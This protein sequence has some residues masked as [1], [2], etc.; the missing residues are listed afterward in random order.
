[1]LEHIESDFVILSTRAMMD[2]AQRV[3]YHV[4]TFPE[5]RG[6][7]S[8]RQLVNSLY[9][10]EFADGEMEAEVRV[11]LRGKKIFLFANAAR[12]SLGY[13]V[14]QNKIELYHTIDALRRAQAES[15]TLFEPYC[16]CSRSDRVT[17]RNSVGFW[18]HYKTLR[19]LGV[20]H[21][22][23][24]Q[25]HSDKS[26]T[27]VDPKGCAIDDVPANQ[28]IE[29]YIADRFIRPYEG[30][31]REI[32]SSW[33]FCSV[34]AGG[35]NLAKRYATDFDCHLMVAH[36]TR[37]Y[38]QVN[39]VDS[40]RILSDTPLKDKV[41]W[42]VDDMI[43][44]AGS[45]YA[46]VYELRKRGVADIN[47]ATVHPVFSD[48]GIQRLC[49]L[50]QEKILNELLVVDTIECDNLIE[51]MPFLSVISSARR[52]AE[53]VMHIHEKKSLSL[54]FNTFNLS[55][56]LETPRLFSEVTG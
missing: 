33:I 47:I 30:D 1:M 35:E 13:S 44:T 18:V 19:S 4:E 25:L 2:Y 6:R 36:K 41:I 45:V 39:T 55:E 37:N 23:T 24:Y 50:H 49:K 11:S 20:D 31:P 51:A 40:M 14:E 38:A 27:V 32:L 48:K 21:I 22:I 10:E 29:E 43:D 28:L 54:F 17:R 12:N 8:P 16:S 26:K 56:Y 7:Q 52:S 42:I 46:L 9:I 5:F 53:I 15:I 34:D 3:A